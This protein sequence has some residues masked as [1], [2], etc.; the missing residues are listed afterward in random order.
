MHPP[1]RWSALNPCNY[2]HLSKP[3][4][5]SACCWIFIL[6]YLAEIRCKTATSLVGVAH[7]SVH[8]LFSMWTSKALFC[9]WMFVVSP[10]HIWGMVRRDKFVFFHKNRW[11]KVCHLGLQE[12]L[13]IW[14]LVW[15]KT[16]NYELSHLICL[17]F[18]LL[19]LIACVTLQ[20]DNF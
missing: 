3:H 17:Y 2:F 14:Q 11:I 20:F 9:F 5:M 13:H 10:Y 19:L 8:R 6:R 16:D 18:T 15:G 7:D 12:L 1:S 4:M